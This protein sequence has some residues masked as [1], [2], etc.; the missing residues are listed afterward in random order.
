MRK[1]KVLII[2]YYW[3]P[4]GGGGV[5]RWLKF[6]KY[7]PDNGWEP[8]IFTPDN[9]EF[10]VIDKSLEN[11][12]APAL[13]VIKYPI[14]EPYQL[15]KKLS[16]RSAQDRVN[17]GLL[18][19]DKKIGLTEKISLW[20]RGNMLIPDPRI[21]WVRPA[22]RFLESEW[23]KL[24]PD[25][26]VSTGPPHSMH[27]IAMRLQK[28]F[29]IPWIVD[30]RDPWSK[31]DFL[32]RFYPG[33]FALRKQQKLEKRVLNTATAILSV[34]ETWG[35]DIRD[36]TNKKVAV[37]TNGFD[38]SD[39][40]LTK[41][42]RLPEKFRISHMGIINSLRNPKSLWQALSELCKEIP[43]L[44]NDLELKL[45]GTVD[46]GLVKEIKE[47]PLLKDK[48][49]VVPYIPHQDVIKEYEKSA[50]LLLL[51][52][53]SKIAKG[54]IPGKLFEYLASG[55]SI[56][57]LGPVDSD[58]SKIITE[59]SSGVTI[60]P[61]DKKAI[62]KSISELYWKYKQN[63]PEQKE[64]NIIKYSRENLT[65]DLVELFNEII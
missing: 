25:L 51:L 30:F 24:N 42:K 64:D 57:A 44:Q 58:V 41:P 29:N 48:L 19:D 27:L 2:T 20:I 36:V 14:W 9:P 53:D 43:A 22:T 65:K 63:V 28:K 6:A 54:H 35:M 16:G 39:F 26:I 32:S 31:L 45:I 7:L 37:I 61:T 1:K 23:T 33:K 15:F 11:D 3:P 60:A 38:Q 13:K 10:P 47:Y 55:S 62:K 40:N 34:S 46:P 8:I 59:N 21:F 49:H 50:C 18:F 5:Q 12:I 4:S 17:T 52:N 56:L